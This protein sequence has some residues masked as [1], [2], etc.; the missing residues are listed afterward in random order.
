[1]PSEYRPVT[2]SASKGIEE[3]PP[4]EYVHPVSGTSRRF[5]V[6]DRFHSTKNP[7]KSELCSFHNINLCEQAATIRTSVQEARNKAKKDKRIQSAC[8]QSFQMH[9]FYNYLMEF[10]Q[11]EKIVEEQKR[12]ISNDGKES[13]TR[14][15]FLRI[16]K[17]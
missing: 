12:R 6:G 16:V 7:H 8:T 11:N 3:Y 17:L 2:I 9:F 14:D 4:Q 1:M 13:I 5:V 10:Y 15:K